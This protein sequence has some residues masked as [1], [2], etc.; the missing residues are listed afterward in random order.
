M[1]GSVRGAAGNCRPYR[2][3]AVRRSTRLKR[4]IAYDP[5]VEPCASE[6]RLTRGGSP[7]TPRGAR[8]SRSRASTKDL[9]H[10]A[11]ET[12]SR[13]CVSG[14]P[15]HG[16][17]CQMR[18]DGGDGRHRDT[19]IVKVRTEGARRTKRRFVLAVS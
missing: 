13:A 10:P 4:L 11:L 18:N 7:W 2:D 3:T 15:V 12:K 16:G 5:G 1:S 8:W 9:P 14:E 6:R 19:K 17:H